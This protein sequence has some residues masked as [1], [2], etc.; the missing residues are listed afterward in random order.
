LLKDHSSY[1]A[2]EGGAK[3]SNALVHA[4]NHKLV[5][6]RSRVKSNHCMVKFFGCHGLWLVN[7]M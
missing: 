7:N 6:K 4:D 5:L 2:E 1:K 3:L